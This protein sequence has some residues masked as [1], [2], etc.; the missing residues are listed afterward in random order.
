MPHCTT[1]RRRS[2]VQV[3]SAA[4]SVGVSVTRRPPCRSSVS[5]RRNRGATDER[6]D[7]AGSWEPENLPLAACLRSVLISAFQFF[8]PRPA[9]DATGR[10]A[11]PGGPV[12]P[13]PARTRSDRA[14]RAPGAGYEFRFRVIFETLLATTAP[15]RFQSVE[16]KC[17]DARGHLAPAASPAAR[18]ANL[19]EM[20]SPAANCLSL[21]G[22]N[23]QYP[24]AWQARA[25]VPH[26][27]R[28]W[29]RFCNQ[30]G[31]VP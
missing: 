7:T 28:A 14:G 4:R 17:L 27:V 12:A 21:T 9:V 22:A 6:V 19:A 8:A 13:G 15:G 24:S 26:S 1:L 30:E 25:F 20:L 11:G 2:L 23:V 31:K 29:P 3:L 16:A 18:S 10:D 5:E